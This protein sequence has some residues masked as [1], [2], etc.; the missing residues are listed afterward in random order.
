VS[1]ERAALGQQAKKDCGYATP[2]ELIPLTGGQRDKAL[3]CLVRATLKQNGSMFPKRV[4]PGATITSASELQGMLVFDVQ[5]APNHPRASAKGESETNFD[6]VLSNRTC[7]DKWLGGIIDA[8]M[9]DGKQARTVIVYR[10][11]DNAGTTLAATAVT[12]CSG[13]E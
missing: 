10:L 8:G 5:L 2:Q 11:L 7:Q 9:E 4:E 1:A 6:Q 13:K 12:Q 3:L